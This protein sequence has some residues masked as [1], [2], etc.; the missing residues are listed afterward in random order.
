MKIG[1]LSAAHSVHTVRW[2]N[3]LAKKG[4]E[5]C[6]YSLPDHMDADNAIDEAVT[7]RYLKNPGVGGYTSNAG[8]LKKL[9][10]EDKPDILNAHY[11][12]GYGTLARKSKF[13]PLLLSVWGS[14]VLIFPNKSIFHKYLLKKNLKNADA[15][16]STSK[17]MG[18]KTKKLLN[19]AK[20]V[21]ITPFG[22]DT[23]KFSSRE[24]KH[25]G[26]VIGIVKSMDK[27]Y[28]IDILLRAFKI[29]TTATEIP[30]SLK[31]YGSG[32]RLEGYK[33]LAGDLKIKDKVQFMGRI[34]HEE[35]PGALNEMDI[36]CMPSLSESFGVSALEAMSCKLPVV[37]SDADG[38]KEIMIDKVTG[39]VVK[40]GKDKALCEKLLSLTEDKKLRIEMGENARNHVINHYSWQESVS[41]META[42][43]KT[44]GIYGNQKI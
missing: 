22:I 29:L 41:Q 13:H 6:L 11:A 4:H 3:A 21:F 7:V 1:V 9:L 5:V 34:I 17:V 15:I 30:V 18:E 39:F 27:V 33:Q 26:V 24:N 28:G 31:I 2:V 23:D 42:L 38:L 32:S 36:F 14:D 8:E 10:S 12:T 19:S 20:E 35:V 40:K 16:A 43:E 25:E 37:C 44:R